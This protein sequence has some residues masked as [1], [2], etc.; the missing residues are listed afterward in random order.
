MSNIYITPLEYKQ[1][2]C[3]ILIFMHNNNVYS[4]A[5]YYINLFTLSLYW[6]LNG[7]ADLPCQASEQVA[8]LQPVTLSFLFICLSPSLTHSPSLPS[9]PLPSPPPSP[10]SP[11]RREQ[12]FFLW[13][14]DTSPLNVSDRLS[15]SHGNSSSNLSFSG[16]TEAESGLYRV[17]RTQYEG[18]EAPVVH[19]L[20]VNVSITAGEPGVNLSRLPNSI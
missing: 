14:K 18:L 7:S 12:T 3:I 8:V 10:L 4:C 9:L 16:V 13:E 6:S 5:H 11:H 19:S 20:A 2:W 1:D 15:V 17:V